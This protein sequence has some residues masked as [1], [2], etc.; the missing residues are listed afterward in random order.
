VP[1]PNSGIPISI[2]VPDVLATTTTVVN[3]VTI[4][5]IGSR[6]IFAPG[7]SYGLIPGTL[8]PFAI[9]NF[10]SSFFGQPYNS[11]LEKQSAFSKVDLR[12]TWKFNDSISIQGFVTNVTNKTT[13]TRFVW[14]GSGALQASYAASRL[15][16]AK[17][18][19][20]F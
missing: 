1:T 4:A 18:S 8:T 11:T 17:A 15:W 20:K 5:P 14:G 3:G 10:S 6:R 13:A 16:R 2:L 19:F 7:Y 12:L 9:I